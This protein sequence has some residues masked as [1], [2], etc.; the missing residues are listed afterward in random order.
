MRRRHQREL[1]ELDRK[2]FHSDRVFEGNN[3]VK[4]QLWQRHAREQREMLDLLR[5]T[6]DS[7]AE[8]SIVLPAGP[9][10]GPDRLRGL[11]SKARKSR[12]AEDPAPPAAPAVGTLGDAEGPE[13]PGGTPPPPPSPNASYLLPSLAGSTLALSQACSV[14]ESLLNASSEHQVLPDELT[15]A[16]S[17]LLQRPASAGPAARALRKGLRPGASDNSTGGRVMQDRR[18]PHPSGRHSSLL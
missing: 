4:E 5:T 12:A 11:R 17:G 1:Y 16:L 2:S 18:A 13:P 15:D 14:V 3:T 6:L 9:T 10:A 8:G 7:S